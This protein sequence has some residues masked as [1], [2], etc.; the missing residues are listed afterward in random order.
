MS[1]KSNYPQEFFQKYILRGL[2]QNPRDIRFLFQ[3]IRRNIQNKNPNRNY[4]VD[5]ISLRVNEVCNLR[6]KSCGQ[7]GENGHLLNKLNNKQKL[8]ELSFD[9]VKNIIYE[10]KKDSPVYYVWGGEPGLWRPLIPFFEELAKNNLIGSLVTNCQN[11]EPMLEDLIKPGSLRMLFI[12]LD[13][14]D[15]ENHNKIRPTA[16]GNDSKNFEKTLKVIEKVD[17]IK[18]KRNLLYPLVVPISVVSK[19]N[20]N[21][22]KDIRKLIEDKTQLHQIFYGWYITEERANSHENVFDSLF[23][24]KP[25]RH[26]GYL[27]SCFNDIDAGE[28]ATSIQEIIKDAKGKNS[29]PQIIPG[30]YS[31]EEIE[32]YYNDHSW[33]CGFSSCTSIYHSAEVS[34]DGTV[35]PCRDYQDYVCGNIYEKSFYEI[36]N[37]KEY[38]NFRK[39][40]KNGLMPVCTRCCGLQGF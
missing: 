1:K 25:S 18:R 24:F 28:V 6:C 7:W 34:P 35:T 20:Y 21:H 2:L 12:S 19:H 31:K 36:W 37:G 40:L 22:L 14:W 39:Q 5:Q 13:A 38:K 23:G 32:K 3:Q 29:I 15:A 30:I 4:P 8:D 11:I 17:E 27:K 16:N 10:T 33:D 26:R 9:V